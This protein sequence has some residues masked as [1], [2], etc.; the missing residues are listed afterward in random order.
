MFFPFQLSFL[1]IVLLASVGVFF[2]LQ[3]LYHFLVFGKIFKYKTPNIQ[4]LIQWQPVS[5]VISA[6]SELENLKVLIP[7][8]LEQDYPNFEIVIIDDASWDGTTGFLE[9]LQKIEPKLKAVFVTEDMKKNSKGKKLALTLGIKAAKNE[10]LLLTD[11]D[12]MPQSKEWIKQMALPYHLQNETEIVLGYSPYKAVKGFLGVLCSM[13]NLLT[14]TSYFAFAIGKNP[15]MGV[16]RNLSYK[17]SLFFKVKG[18]AS[19]H[20]IASGDDDLFIQDAANSSNTAVCISPNAFM[21]TGSKTT[22]KAWFAQKKRH[23]Y[24]GKYYKAKHQRSLAYFGFTH[25]LFW[26]IVAACLCFTETRYW[27]LALVALFWIIK[28][29]FIYAIFK[30]FGKANKAFWLPVFDVLFVAYNIVFGFYRLFG[31][32]KK[33]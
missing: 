2:G 13:E 31:K 25:L 27:A 30:R 19:H 11:A 28:I 22:F 10:I 14:A 32:Q 26:L 9:E 21:P 16:G 24:V 7:A 15:Y 18:F 4:P 5:I 20:H 12:C 8:L 6:R 29:P 1:S 17:R 3:L 23:N 33:W